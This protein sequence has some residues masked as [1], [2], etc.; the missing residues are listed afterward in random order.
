MPNPVNPARAA[1]AGRVHKLCV[2]E[3]TAVRGPMER[4][5]NTAHI[6]SEDLLNAAAVEAIRNGGEVFTLLPDQAPAS[7]AL[8]AILRY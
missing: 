5:L 6:E 3:G 1:A 8:A 2:R 4:E 7:E